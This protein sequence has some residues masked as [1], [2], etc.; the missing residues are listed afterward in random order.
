MDID[1]YLKRI[2][3]YGPRD[4]GIDTLVRLHKAHLYSV[5]FE[6]LDIHLGRPIIL[7]EAKIIRKVVEERRGGFCYEL[8]G[9]FCAL[10]RKLGFEVTMLSAGVIRNDGSFGPPFDHMTLLVQLDDRWLAD[11]GFGDSFCEPLRLDDREEQSQSD[12]VYRIVEDGGRF[13][14]QRLERGSWSPQYRFGLEGH[15]LADY[16]EMCL[17][18]QTSPDSTFTQRRTCTRATPQGR[19][20]V[21]GMR[22]IE[23][24]SGN[25]REVELEGAGEWRAALREHFGVE[26]ER[27]VGEAPV[28][29]RFS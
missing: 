12:D 14:L 16:A 22:L 19:V 11:V 13:I 15:T 21:T 18:H 20:T 9:A 3:Y 23:T 5:P 27:G 2:N 17:Y 26:L 28:I 6:N 10:L 24:V 29:P 1:A 8:N 25:R 7:D 4:P